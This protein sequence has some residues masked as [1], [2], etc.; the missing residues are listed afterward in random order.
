MGPRDLHPSASG[1]GGAQGAHDHDGV[2]AG[3][4]GARMSPALQEAVRTCEAITRRRARNF[5]YG[6]RLTPE[7][8]RWA[9]YAVY[10]WMREADDLADGAGPDRAERA[11]RIAR[12]RADTD[13]AFKGEPDDTQP[14]MVA[15]AEAVRRFALEPAEFHDMLAGQMGDLDA[16]RFETWEALREFCYRVAGTVGVVCI[17][18]WGFHG[19]DAIRLAVDRGIAFQLTNVLRDLREDLDAGRCYLPLREYAAM[20]LSPDDL[21]SW[22]LP[23]RCTEFIRAQCERARAHYERS[24]PLD[25]M[26]D[27]SCLPTLWAMT[28]IYRGILG[29]I[30]RDPRITVA[31][32]ARLSS[33]RK[34]WIAWRAT[35][36]RP[37]ASSR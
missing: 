37:E 11:R 32:R 27:P 17:R 3:P 1:L 2:V 20:D 8:R 5:H 36:M 23:D 35:R 26:I 7:D 16:A 34:A 22:R 4:E 19:A 9:M 10:A 12:F 30:E 25:R 14:C 33:F 13:A 15:L 6:L 24:A 31:G 18:V 28:Q 29:R 21:R